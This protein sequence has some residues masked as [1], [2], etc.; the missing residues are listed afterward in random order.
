MQIDDLDS[1]SQ[2]CGQGDQK[3]AR[4]ERSTNLQHQGQMINDQDLIQDYETGMKKE[5]INMAEMH[6]DHDK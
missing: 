5:S 4:G 6:N 3:Q 2:Q 1:G